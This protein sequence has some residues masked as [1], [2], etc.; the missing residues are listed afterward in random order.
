MPMPGASG[1]DG[2][3]AIPAIG[4]LIGEAGCKRIQGS[5]VLVI[6]DTGNVSSATSCRIR[7]LRRF[8]SDLAVF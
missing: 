4:S 7:S 3:I 6:V 8:V 1:Q 5:R 2:G